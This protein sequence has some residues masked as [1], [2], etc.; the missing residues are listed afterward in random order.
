MYVQMYVCMQLYICMCVYMYV[1]MYV[2]MYVCMYI[3]IDAYARACVRELCV[4]CICV[5]VC[6]CGTCIQLIS[7]TDILS[8]SKCPWGEKNVHFLSLGMLYGIVDVHFFFFF[9]RHNFVGA[10]SLEPSLVETPD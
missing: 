6:M 3:C 1:F 10:I 7:G 2:C 5:C 9:F 8:T 4:V